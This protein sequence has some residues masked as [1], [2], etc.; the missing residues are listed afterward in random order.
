MFTRL[1]EAG[2]YGVERVERE[3]NCQ[4]C[5]SP[6]LVDSNGECCVS[7]ENLRVGLSM[8]YYIIE[9]WLR[10]MSDLVQRDGF[11]EI[12]SGSEG[13]IA[14]MALVWSC[15]D[16]KSSFTTSSPPPMTCANIHYH[17]CTY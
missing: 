9:K 2:F 17:W 6:G 8:G 14:A 15:I 16:V 12:C 10:T 5:H 13:S 11:A 3:V 1:L 4:T 7:Q